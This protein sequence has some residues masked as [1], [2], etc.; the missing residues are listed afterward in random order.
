[1]TRRPLENNEKVYWGTGYAPSCAVHN[2]PM[3]KRL[4]RLVSDGSAG[5]YVYMC[6]ISNADG[7]CRER[8]LLCDPDTHEPLF[9]T[10]RTGLLARN[11][12][13]NL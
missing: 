1:M 3:E 13:F 8:Y 2:L 4:S 11:G 9:G 12:I 5:R 6:A 10:C 7:G